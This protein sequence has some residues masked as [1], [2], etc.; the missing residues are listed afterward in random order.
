MAHISPIRIVTKSSAIKKRNYAYGNH[1]Y[2]RFPYAF[3]FSSVG[4][5]AGDTG[6]GSGFEQPGICARQDEEGQEAQGSKASDGSAVGLN[7]FQLHPLRLERP[8]RSL[9]NLNF[10]LFAD[11]RSVLK[12]FN[13]RNL[14][15]EPVHQPLATHRHRPIAFPVFH[16]G[17]IHQRNFKAFIASNATSFEHYDQCKWRL[18]GAQ[19]SKPAV[20]STTLAF[21]R[22]RIA[23]QL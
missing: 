7:F 4:R 5:F 10:L 9:N 8:L 16:M 2:K 11:W 15:R 19:V 20:A 14:E 21:I 6:C 13:R 23:L 18:V 12:A 3:L 22:R 1:F 17:A